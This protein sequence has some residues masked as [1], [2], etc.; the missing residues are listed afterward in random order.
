MAMTTEVC[1]CRMAAVQDNYV[2]DNEIVG[3][4][5]SIDTCFIDKFF[6]NPVAVRSSNS[7][8]MATPMDTACKQI[9]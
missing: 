6:G 1:T 8:L 5:V 9:K 3:C 7:A 4:I 2:S